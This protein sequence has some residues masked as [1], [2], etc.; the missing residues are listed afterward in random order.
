M[1][2]WV[3]EQ[4]STERLFVGDEDGVDD[5]EGDADDEVGDEE[6]DVGD[7]GASQRGV[8]LPS[9]SESV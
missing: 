4:S 8:S 6:G 3:G 7:A 1:Q 5:K 9:S 2:S